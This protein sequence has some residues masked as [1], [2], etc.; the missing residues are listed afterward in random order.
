MNPLRNY[1]IG[2]ALCLTHSCIILPIK[3]LCLSRLMERLNRELFLLLFYTSLTSN[4][5][6]AMVIPVPKNADKRIVGPFSS[7]YCFSKMLLLMKYFS[8]IL[9]IRGNHKII[10]TDFICTL[11]LAGNL[12]SGGCYN[13]LEL[14]FY[15][16]WLSKLLG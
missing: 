13:K 10:L 8:E 15:C 2:S 12:I 6:L 14:L 11:L 1:F 16:S 4:F 3:S 7:L 5:L 9:E